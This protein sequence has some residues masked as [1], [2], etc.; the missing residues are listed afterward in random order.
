MEFS[1]GTYLLQTV[2]VAAHELSRRAPLWRTSPWASGDVVDGDVAEV[3][4]PPP[5]LEEHAE[6]PAG[7]RD[8]TVAP[9]VPLGLG[10]LPDDLLFLTV[11]VLDQDLCEKKP[12]KQ[13][14]TD[15]LL[16]NVGNV[17]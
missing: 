4:P 8:V 1:P 3:T 6:R 14:F 9:V 5:R 13:G 15:L 17:P 11:P 10:A 2:A 12:Q 16:D 7:Q